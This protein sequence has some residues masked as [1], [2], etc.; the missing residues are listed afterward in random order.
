[1]SF[2][3]SDP[4]SKIRAATFQTEGTGFVQ[5]R[6]FEI[7]VIFNHIFLFIVEILK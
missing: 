7:E 1:M 5:L 6:F 3:P 4:K 2:C